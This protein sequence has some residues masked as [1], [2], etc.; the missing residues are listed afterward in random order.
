MNVQISLCGLVLSQE[1]TYLGASPDFLVTCDCCGKGVVE[2][3]CPF[4]H[5]DSDITQ[6]RPAFLDANWLSKKNHAYFAQ[7]QGQMAIVGR[8][9]CDFVVYT[10]QKQVIQRIIFDQEFC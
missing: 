8:D 3:K 1:H 7:V 6:D 10:P 2:V 4:K 5:K 9:W